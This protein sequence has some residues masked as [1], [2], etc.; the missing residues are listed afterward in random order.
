MSSN[1]LTVSIIIVEHYRWKSC[2][3]SAKKRCREAVEEEIHKRN[4]RKN[5]Y[6]LLSSQTASSS[7]TRAEINKAGGCLQSSWCASGAIRSWSLLEEIKDDI[8]ISYPQDTIAIIAERKKNAT[9]GSSSTN[10]QSEATSNPALPSAHNLLGTS[11]YAPS[12]APS[13]SN[14]PN[15]SSALGKWAFM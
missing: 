1:F 4:E 3:C 15:N 9:A 5:G 13:S 7:S 2:Y 11:K 14:P 10:I 12:F 6:A 8:E